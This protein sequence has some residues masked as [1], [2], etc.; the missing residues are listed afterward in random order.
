LAQTATEY[1]IILAVVIVI[2]LIVI[3]VMGGIPG[4]GKSG[5]DKAEKA[6]WA[7]ADIAIPAYAN[8]QNNNMTV[9][10]RNNLQEGITIT[11]FSLDNVVYMNAS[12]YVETGETVSLALT[13]RP[14]C[15]SGNTFSYAAAINYTTM[16]GN[17]YS[18]TGDGHKLTGQCAN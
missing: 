3:S 9:K 1:L 6:F 12:T 5:Q 4:I 2:A 11:T 10:I 16:T 13:G 7:T 17:K 14:V 8:S 18:F 15:V